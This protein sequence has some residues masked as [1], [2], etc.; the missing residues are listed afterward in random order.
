MPFVN[1][2]QQVDTDS[3]NIMFILKQN[4]ASLQ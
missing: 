2:Q 1:Y 4:E 3:K